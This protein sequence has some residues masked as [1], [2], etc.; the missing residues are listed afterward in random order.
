[1]MGLSVPQA[2]VESKSIGPEWNLDSLAG[3]F[4]REAKLLLD[5]QEILQRQRSAV[6]QDDLAVVD[7]TVYSAQRI[8]RTLAEARR[9][10]RALLEILGLDRDASVDS[11]DELLGSRMTVDLGLA[12]TELQEAARRVS[13]EL[14]VNKKIL[15][16]AI[17]TGEE[18]IQG[19]RGVSARNTGVY[20]PGATA[21]SPGGDGGV[22]INRQ[23]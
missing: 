4:R 5:L 14:S 19:L 6:A 18:L 9:Q 7:E 16:G 23:I 2:P 15:Q 3:A 8:F 21:G 20:G 1:M 12:R 11:L 22:I 13:R 10:R 17:A